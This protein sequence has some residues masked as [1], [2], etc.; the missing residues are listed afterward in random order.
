MP[1]KL[2]EEIVDD[3]RFGF[4]HFLRLNPKYRQNEILA[5][6]ENLFFEAI[7]PS[8]S[9]IGLRADMYIDLRDGCGPIAVEVGRMK[10]GKWSHITT[11]DGKPMRVLRVGFDRS[12]WMLNPRNTEIE[13]DVMG[14]YRKELQ[15]IQ[16]GSQNEAHDLGTDQNNEK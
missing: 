13:T 9:G 11:Q 4:S 14:F 2:H 7:Y 10:D 3:I 1:S 12:I 6:A 15:Q 16:Q 5:I 8:A